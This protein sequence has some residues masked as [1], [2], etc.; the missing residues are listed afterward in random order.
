MRAPLAI[1]CETRVGNKIGAADCRAEPGEEP[2]VQYG[3]GE[4]PGAGGIDAE[5][6]RQ[7]MAVAGARRVLIADQD[8]RRG[9]RHH[10]DERIE[11]RHI[12]HAPAPGA[13]AVE[14][15]RH[16]PPC[17]EQPAR[18]IGHRLA[19]HRR[20]PVWGAGLRHQTAH[21]LDDDVVGGSGG[22]GT[23]L[24]EPRD[25]GIDEPRVDLLQRIGA[26]AEL[27][28]DAGAEVLHQHIRARRK[29]AGD[30]Q[31]IRR[32]QVQ[33][34][35]SLASVDVLKERAF[36][37]AER[38]NMAVL[39]AARRLDL[40]HV[41]AEIGH[42]GRRVGAG[43]DTCEIE[44]HDALERAGSVRHRRHSPICRCVRGRR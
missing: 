13:F 11:E 22:V 28:H 3:K 5:G 6:C 34:D 2:V 21:R 29:R 8:P 43:E 10:R 1:G 42:Q 25:R 12:D 36:A 7:G 18:D 39:V 19:H 30:F 41:G 35:R 15:G 23:G 27:R 37:V 32:L 16:D 33:H 40:D 4:M 38:P 31:I 44:H 24:A 14:E 20:R 9:G 17:R 26:E